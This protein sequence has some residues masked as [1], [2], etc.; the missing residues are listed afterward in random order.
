LIFPHDVGFQRANG[1][2]PPP[3]LQVEIRKVLQN[4]IKFL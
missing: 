1:D 4:N 2:V 3:V